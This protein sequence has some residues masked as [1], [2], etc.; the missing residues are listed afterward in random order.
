MFVPALVSERETGEWED[1]VWASGVAFANGLEGADV[2][3][4]T[5]AEY[6]G[7]RFDATGVREGNGD[8][9]NLRE[10]VDGLE[11]RYGITAVKRAGGWADFITA[12]PIGTVFV[13]Q[14][15]N[16]AFPARLRGSTFA[17]PHAVAGVRT[18]SLQVALLNPL[19]PSGTAPSVATLDEIRAFYESLP[20][21]EWLVGTTPR[22]IPIMAIT[23]RPE[24]YDVLAGT[25]FFDAP[26]G[27][28]VGDFDAA[29]Q[30]I[31]SVGV[32][33]D[34]SPDSLNLAWRAIVVTSRAIDDRLTDKVVYVQ[35]S[36]LTNGRPDPG[37]VAGDELAA[38]LAGRQAEW[39]RW[40]SELGIPERPGKEA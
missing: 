22:R 28:Q 16:G 37:D 33:M 18:G 40:V 32:P 3:P 8:G 20:G 14:G 13:I 26:G 12:C 4:G 5:R 31:R 11:A 23:L 38:N 17:G 36:R 15:L 7:L 25:P 21:A 10:L 24:L 39:D 2:H 35:T 1:C 9:S 30:G 27:R 29:A 34:A 6:E 19:F